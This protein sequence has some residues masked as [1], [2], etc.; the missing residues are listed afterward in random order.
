MGTRGA[1]VRERLYTVVTNPCYS[2]NTDLKA[3][4]EELRQLDDP[5]CVLDVMDQVGVV[6]PGLFHSIELNVT[7]R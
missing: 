6:D 5:T 1:T 2:K 4:S 7:I 3:A